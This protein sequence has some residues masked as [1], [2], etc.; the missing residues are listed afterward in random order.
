MKTSKIIFISILGIIAL[1][2]MAAFIDLRING[3]RDGRALSTKKQAVPAF[4]VLCINSSDVILVRNDSSYIEV[5]SLTDSLFPEVNYSVKDDT[6]LVS[7]TR[8]LLQYNLS[9]KI[10]SPDALNNI[11]LRN[12]GITL[13]GFGSDTMSIDMD[14]SHLWF[15]KGKDGKSDIHSL[16]L[17][18]K[19]HSHINTDEI[20]VDSVDID[21]RKS[22]AYLD[23]R[24]MKIS[25]TLSD[26]SR[27]TTRQADEISVKKDKTSRIYVNE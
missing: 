12:T 20:N 2:I 24:T 27:I 8:N 25:G 16:N 22:E 14:N 3:L 7:D 5:T 18:A 19:N 21:I 1:I 15:N 4:K 6:L 26:S 23:F 9:V 13:E 10:N 17:L 11:I